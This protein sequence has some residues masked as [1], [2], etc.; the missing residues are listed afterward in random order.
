MPG[1][2]LSRIFPG[3]VATSG[4]ISDKLN[5]HESRISDIEKWENADVNPKN[6]ERD[7]KLDKIDK[8]LS[9][10]VEPILNQH[11]AEIDTL[12][13]E[14]KSKV[15]LDNEQNLHIDTLERTTLDIADLRVK[16]WADENFDARFDT[17]WDI[18]ELHTKADEWFA[19]YDMNLKL[20]KMLD[21]P[22][23]IENYDVGEILGVFD[24][25]G[26]QIKPLPQLSVSQPAVSGAIGETSGGTLAGTDTT[27]GTGISAPG[28]TATP[29]KGTA[30]GTT[31]IQGST[32]TKATDI[33]TGRTLS[34]TI[35]NVYDIED[36]LTKVLQTYWATIY[37]LYVSWDTYVG[38]MSD[39]VAYKSR[40]NDAGDF[41]SGY[42]DSLKSLISGKGNYLDSRVEGIVDTKLKSF[43]ITVESIASKLELPQDQATLLADLTK[44]DSGLNSDK[45]SQHILDSIRFYH[46]N[47]KGYTGIDDILTNSTT[48]L[49]EIN[50][51]WWNADYMKSRFVARTDTWL[52]L[53]G[54][55]RTILDYVDGWWTSVD[56]AGRVDSTLLQRQ[57]W[58]DLESYR[59]KFPSIESH[60][61]KLTSMYNRVS[62][63]DDN[64]KNLISELKAR[65]NDIAA[66]ASALGSDVNTIES[67]VKSLIKLD[68]AKLIDPNN[69]AR[70]ITSLLDILLRTAE[71]FDRLVVLIDGVRIKVSDISRTVEGLKSD[72]KP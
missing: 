67:Y 35:T 59:S 44:T 5:N 54:T 23:G 21:L 15:A 51:S 20:K 27:Q 48:K 56:F 30:T 65:G 4:D 45:P 22:S 7:D 61:K 16:K 31:G 64:I 40:W 34:G 11:D 69:I 1:P 13:T 6:T 62:T 57:A 47:F 19:D 60:T 68:I 71:G 28:S 66:T 17:K 12:S 55:K 26:G 25:I 49:K 36:R 50:D 72:L 58:L 41:V 3:E 24:R 8:Y 43:K 52:G 37:G 29:T 2:I 9:G 63:L 18:T 33:G 32:G 38:S 14:M 53:D 46:S 70:V 39:V 42:G 10:T